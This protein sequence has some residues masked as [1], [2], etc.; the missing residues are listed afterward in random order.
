MEKTK[1]KSGIPEFLKITLT[2]AI[3]GCLFSIHLYELIQYYKGAST[4]IPVWL[5][6]W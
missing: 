3:L 2:G 6:S 5:F 1:Q 4:H